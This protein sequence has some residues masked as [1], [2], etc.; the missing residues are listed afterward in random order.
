MAKVH[1]E[2]I[3]IEIS[4]LVKDSESVTPVVTAEIAATI[5]QVAQ[6]LITGAIV[7]IKEI[8]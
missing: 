2:S 5:E 7:E 1:A 8:K 6:E 4:R 3:T